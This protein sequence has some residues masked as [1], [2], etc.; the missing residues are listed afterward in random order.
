MNFICFTYLRMWSYYT[1]SRS[2]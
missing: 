2:I 1:N